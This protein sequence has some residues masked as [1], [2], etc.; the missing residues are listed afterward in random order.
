MMCKR[1][2]P[3]EELISSV[4]F[5]KHF[6]NICHPCI[7]VC[8]LYHGAVIALHIDYRD[9]FSVVMK[10]SQVLST[11]CVVSNIPQ[12]MIKVYYL[13]EFLENSKIC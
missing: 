8:T 1:P 10:N 13:T 9:L 6:A 2:T 12:Y 5:S 7:T 3:L 11:N 4:A